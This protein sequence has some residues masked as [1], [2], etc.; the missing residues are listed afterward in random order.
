MIRAYAGTRGSGVAILPAAA[1]EASP[2]LADALIDAGFASVIGWLRQVPAAAESLVLFLLHARLVDDGLDAPAAVHSVRE[3]LTEP[4]RIMPAYL[5]A[6]YA[7]VLLETGDQ[8]MA[9][10]PR[11][12]GR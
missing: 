10:G 4:G 3:W 5:P 1:A 8:L 7:V 2:M 6:A 11:C 9:S 12:W